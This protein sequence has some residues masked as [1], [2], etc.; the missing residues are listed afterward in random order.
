MYKQLSE[1][2]RL[3]VGFHLHRFEGNERFPLSEFLALLFRF[4]FQQPGLDN[5]LVCLELWCQLASYL[6]VRVQD[7]AVHREQILDL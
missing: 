2:L 4:T 1:F 3:F 5:Q 7:R 6:A